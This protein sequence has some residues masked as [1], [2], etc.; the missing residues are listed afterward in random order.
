M[1]VSFAYDTDYEPPAPVVEAK[2]RAEG[3]VVVDALLDTGA[4]GTMILISVL[5]T[6]RARFA[7]THRM[8]GVI[9]VARAVEL[10]ERDVLRHLIVTLDGI[11]GL[12]ETS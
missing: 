7:E 12:A 8:R 4:D 10:I 3:E 9:G 5:R 1:A 11:S 2:L 6:I